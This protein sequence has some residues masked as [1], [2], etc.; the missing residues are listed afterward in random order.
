MKRK[1]KRK[2]RKKKRVQIN[3]NNAAFLQ[4][5]IPE[6]GCGPV[7]FFFDALASF[8]TPVIIQES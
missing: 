5:N 3:P 2:K 6:P 1:K 4:E 8:S 7:L